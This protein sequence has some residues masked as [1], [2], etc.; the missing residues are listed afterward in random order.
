M[1]RDE[2]IAGVVGNECVGDEDGGE[3]DNEKADDVG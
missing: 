3:V 1:E 2:V